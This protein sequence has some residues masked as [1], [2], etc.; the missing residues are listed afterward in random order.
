MCPATIW[1]LPGG[2]RCCET[3]EHTTHVYVSSQSP[4]RH[5]AE[6]QES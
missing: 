5:T 6:V 1:D 2:L 4:D 3:G